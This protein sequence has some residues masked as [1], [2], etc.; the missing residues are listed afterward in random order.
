VDL[1]LRLDDLHAIVELA[2][3]AHIGNGLE[4]L[5]QVHALHGSGLELGRRRVVELRVCH[6]CLPRGGEHVAV[7][8][9]PPQRTS[10]G[11]GQP[12]LPT[13][14]AAQAEKER[15][16]GGCHQAVANLKANLDPNDGET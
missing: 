1:H 8:G 10:V 12:K 5:A 4:A 6:G 11:E 2:H 14:A 15:V 7:L 13:G 3:R 16:V 9:P